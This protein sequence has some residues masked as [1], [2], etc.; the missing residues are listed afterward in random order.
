[1]EDSRELLTLRFGEPTPE[2]RGDGLNA[3]E[4]TSRELIDRPAIAVLAIVVGAVNPAYA[5]RAPEAFQRAKVLLTHLKLGRTPPPR[6]GDG[7]FPVEK[8]RC[9]GQLLAVQLFRS[10]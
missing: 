2:K 6:R 8:S 10:Q 3:L 9:P 1:M 7:A 5:D 4:T